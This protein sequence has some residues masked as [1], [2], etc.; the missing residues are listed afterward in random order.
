MDV[1]RH[2]GDV[3]LHQCERCGPEHDVYHACRNRR[4][5]KCQHQDT[6]AW[7]EARR[8]ELLPVPSCQVVLTR[9]RDLRTL[10]RHHQN[11]RYD[12]W[13]RAAAPAVITLAADPH[14]VGGRIG[15]RCGLH[16]WTRALEYQP[17]VHCRV[18]AGGVSPDRSQW[19]PGRTSSLVPVDALSTRLRGLFVDWVCQERPDRTRPEVLWTKGWVVY[20]KPTVQGTEQVLNDRGRSVHRIALTHSRLLASEEGQVCFRYQDAR[21]H[22]WKP[23]T[24]PALECIRR[25]LQHVL[26]PGFHN[27][28]NDGLW[29]PGR[30]SRRRHLQR[31]LA[32]PASDS[33]PAAPAPESCPQDSWCPPLRAGQPCPRCGQGLLVVVR[34]LPRLQRGPP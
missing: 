12:S 6:E 34:L 15:V 3:F 5:P 13:R 26:P 32:R 29:R 1:N 33:P 11:D 14:D 17:H 7:L 31:C 8:Q 4:C 18:P 20:C 25:F 9:P 23:M 30:R 28:R 16:T 10:V 24:L 19:R 2:V 22:G 21:Q 27:V